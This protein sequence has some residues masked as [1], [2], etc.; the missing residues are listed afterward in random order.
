MLPGVLV[1]ATEVVGA[2]VVVNG[3]WWQLPESTVGSEG[4]YVRPASWVA[5][6]HSLLMAIKKMT[7]KELFYDINCKFPVNGI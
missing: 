7:S 6:P 1:V 3:I 5:L 4:Q 2:G